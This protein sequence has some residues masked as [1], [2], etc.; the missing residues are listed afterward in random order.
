VVAVGE[1]Q[2]DGQVVHRRSFQV[3]PSWQLHITIRNRLI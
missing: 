2:V 1:V 3:V